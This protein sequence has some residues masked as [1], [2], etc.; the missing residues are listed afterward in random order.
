MILVSET[1]KAIF[2]LS[3]KSGIIEL[4]VGVEEVLYIN[5]LEIKN[6]IL[7]FLSRAELTI[8]MFS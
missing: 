2:W 5:V 8:N 1:S 7:Q 4:T 6:Q 3:K